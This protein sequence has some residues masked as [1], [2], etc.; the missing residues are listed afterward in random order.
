MVPHRLAI[1]TDATTNA[2]FL[3][4]IVMPPPP[5]TLSRM[6]YTMGVSTVIYTK[7]NRIPSKI[8]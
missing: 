1:A 2:I 3:R 8:W 6:P 7:G 5:R 4:C